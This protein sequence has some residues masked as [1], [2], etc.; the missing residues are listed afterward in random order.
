MKHEAKQGLTKWS[1]MYEALQEIPS[2][3]T[4]AATRIAEIQTATGRILLPTSVVLPMASAPSLANTLK[5]YTPVD[6]YGPLAMVPYRARDV[7][8][9]P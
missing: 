3:L 5:D 8:V 4:H 2:H 6:P 1:A 9:K 7:A